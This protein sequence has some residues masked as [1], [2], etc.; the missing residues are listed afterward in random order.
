MKIDTREIAKEYRMGHWAQI[1]KDRIESG[2]SI[3]SY[4]ETQGI[5][6][7]VYHYWQRKLRTATYE[8]TTERSQ[9]AGM[10]IQGFT[11][12]KIMEQGEASPQS[13]ESPQ[14]LQ[15]VHSPQALGQ[16]I[17]EVSGYKITANSGYPPETLASVLRGL[18]QQC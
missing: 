7:N 3:K 11:E 4:C 18:T 5:H 1:M 6:Q 17:I 10:P 16:I 15:S 8:M 13:V 2:L 9:T 12:V 14:A